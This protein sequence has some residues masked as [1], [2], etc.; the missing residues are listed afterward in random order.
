M[1]LP[2]FKTFQSRASSGWIFCVSLFTRRRTPPVRYRTVSEGSSSTCKG[3]KVLGSEWMQKRSSPPY[4]PKDN[5]AQ[6]ISRANKTGLR[7]IFVPP[8]SP[9][10]PG[11]SRLSLRVQQAAQIAKIPDV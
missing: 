5:E 7:L 2:P 8:P 11:T 9:A 6:R 3:L 1:V 10:V 4:C